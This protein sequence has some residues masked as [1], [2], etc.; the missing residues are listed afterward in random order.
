MLV[1]ILNN[2]QNELT[3]LFV[4]NLVLCATSLRFIVKIRLLKLSFVYIPSAIYL[5]PNPMPKAIVP[6]SNIT[7]A[8]GVKPPPK[9]I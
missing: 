2:S 4:I 5:F 6:A 7:V 1:F 8:L 3:I 9:T